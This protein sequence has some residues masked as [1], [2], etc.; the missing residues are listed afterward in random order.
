MIGFLISR[1]MTAYQLGHI[2]GVWEPF[3]A[4]DPADPRNGTEEIIT[5]LVGTSRRWR[6]MPWLVFAFG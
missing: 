5:G 2:E 4:G 6:T 1:Y 3:F